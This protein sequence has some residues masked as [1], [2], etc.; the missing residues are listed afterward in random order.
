MTTEELDRDRVL[1]LQCLAAAEVHASNSEVDNLDLQITR[2]K[3]IYEFVTTSD[4]EE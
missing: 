1:R 4:K 3:T 2:A